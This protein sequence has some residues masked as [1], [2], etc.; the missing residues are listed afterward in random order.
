MDHKQEGPV[1]QANEAKSS[2]VVRDNVWI[3]ADQEKKS[4]RVTV[5]ERNVASETITWSGL[6]V[7]GFSLQPE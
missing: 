7:C 3:R 1:V 2:D 5:H 4:V 6:R